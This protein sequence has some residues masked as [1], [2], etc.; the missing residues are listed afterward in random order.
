MVLFSMYVKW[1]IAAIAAVLVF[2]ALPVMDVFP[3][4]LL[5]F[6][7][8]LIPLW[9]L[10]S[11][12]VEPGDEFTWARTFLGLPMLFM[13]SALGAF[14]WWNGAIWW[15]NLIAVVVLVMGI[16]LSIALKFF[17]NRMDDTDHSFL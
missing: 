9:V 17:A 13:Y 2:L 5:S 1:R 4:V 3:R 7:F 12:G 6:G 8:G 14:V 11:G 15:S 10:P 16:G